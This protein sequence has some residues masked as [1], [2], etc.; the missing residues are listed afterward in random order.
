MTQNTIVYLGASLYQEERKEM[1][2]SHKGKPWEGRVCQKVTVI[3][4]AWY[5]QD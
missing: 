4:N 5:G 2:C 1:A 3:I